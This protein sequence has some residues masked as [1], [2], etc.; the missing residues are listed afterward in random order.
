MK[1]SVRL[2]LAFLMLLAISIP[3][4][5]K[6]SSEAEKLTVS[7]KAF[8]EGSTI[9]KEFTADGNDVSPGI[10]WSEVPKGTKSLAITCED[11]D[12]PAG[13]WFHWIVYDIPPTTTRMKQGVVK[14]PDLP[15]GIK[16][17][18]N[19]FGKSGYNGPSPPKGPVHHY[20][21][22][23]FALDSKL[24]LKAGA[25]KRA[26]YSAIKGKVLGQGMLTGLYQRK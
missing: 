13:T 18:T 16:Q 4:L 1:N 22:K 12:A 10:T 23:V 2:C 6:A 11:P 15:E 24:S 17:G 26:F 5:A 3:A 21:F 25:D 14:R 19:D 9:P 8:T 20:H 7:S